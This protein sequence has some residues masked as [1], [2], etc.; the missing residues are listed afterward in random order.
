MS[1][2]FIRF[3]TDKKFV[4][5]EYPVYECREIQSVKI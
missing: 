4:P 3:Q 5:L 2:I 1:Y